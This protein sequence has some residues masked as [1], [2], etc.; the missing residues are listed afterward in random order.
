MKRPVLHEWIEDLQRRGRYGFSLKEAVKSLHLTSET[1]VKRS[2]NR[3]VRKGKIRSV[4]KGYYIIIPPEYFEAGIIP[5]LYFIDGLMEFLRRKYYLALLSAAAIFGAGHHRPQEY[6][7][8]TEFPPMR[9]TTKGGIRINYISKKKFT[10]KLLE[11]SKTETGY[12][13]VSSPILTAC[14]LVQFEKKI[15]GI[16][17][18]AE[19]LDELFEDVSEFE[20][21]MILLDYSPVTVI[22]RLGYLLEY[23]LD[24]KNIADKLFR[25]VEKRGIKLFRIPLKSGFGKKKYSS[26]NR[27]NVYQNIDMEI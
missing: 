9:S 8:V 17:R 5:P 25:L 2:L 3:L 20:P 13:N 24:K 22:Q 1:G 7:V 4:H 19:V 23:F 6:F 16:N 27:W 18:A 14:D 21:P 15:G 10:T 12:I 11:K 26:N